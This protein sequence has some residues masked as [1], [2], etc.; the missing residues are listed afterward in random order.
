MIKQSNF[1][2]GL[3]ISAKGYKLV[4][5]D[6]EKNKI[7]LVHADLFPVSPIDDD[8]L[9][10]KTLKDSL[11]HCR[12]ALKTK[13]TVFSIPLQAAQIRFLQL[14][15]V[16]GNLREQI[17]WEMEQQTIGRPVEPVIDWVKT[18][19]AVSPVVVDT[20]SKLPSD[21]ETEEGEKEE[22]VNYLPVI[23]LSASTDKQRLASWNNAIKKSGLIPV[24]CDV[25]ALALYNVF[26]EG[27]PEELTGANY[28][29]D[30][31]PDRTLLIW[32]V[33]G[34]LVEVDCMIG[35]DWSGAEAVSRSVAKIKLR[36]KDMCDGHADIAQP[37]KFFI[38]GEIASD[39]RLR[40]IVFIEVGMKGELLDPFRAVA[41]SEE[42]FSQASLYGSAFAISIGLTLRGTGESE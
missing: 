1:I 30:I 29:F 31:S 25:D 36:L 10:H 7:T 37:D 40:D 3:E 9:M 33:E 15:P 28:L 8:S 16:L 21:G 6:I 19:G 22:I 41:A 11:K 14:D 23:Y 4:H 17:I 32:I 2:I 27:Y 26:V 34:K 24:V 12:K 42:I 18:G 20:M 13:E 35:L 39:S 5:R 38:S